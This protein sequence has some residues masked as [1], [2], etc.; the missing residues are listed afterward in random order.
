M[1]DRCGKLFQMNKNIIKIVLLCVLFFGFDKPI[2]S[3]KNLKD[4][5]F[6]LEKFD[7]PKVYKYS[8][9]FNTD[10]ILYWH[11]ESSTLNNKNYLTTSVFDQDLKQIETFKEEIN[12]EGSVISKYTFFFDSQKTE[13]I[14]NDN[15]VFK[16]NQENYS[17][18]KWSVSYPYLG[19]E[20]HI[21][22]TRSYDNINLTKKFN[23]EEFRTVKFRDDFSFTESKG[24][25][26]N[27]YKYYQYSYYSEG[28]GLLEYVRYF[29]EGDLVYYKLEDILLEEEWS[30]IVGGK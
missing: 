21:E 10:E 4:Y 11:L 1:Q 27:T 19:G 30:K 28:I 2:N 14:I 29:P 15:D 25:Q 6:Q 23:D 8:N 7:K 5:Y 9:T 17:S 22:K 18:I 12:S 24:D 13:T 20:M 26:Q 3:N 16:W